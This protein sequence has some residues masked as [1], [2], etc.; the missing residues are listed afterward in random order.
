LE[1]KNGTI[2]VIMGKLLRQ[3]KPRLSEELRIDENGKPF[4]WIT[5]K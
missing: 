2:K 5:A 1:H 3:T 4:L